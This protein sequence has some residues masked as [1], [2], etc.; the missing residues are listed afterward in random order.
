MR[1][2][3]TKMYI[4]RLEKKKVSFEDKPTMESVDNLVS[5]ERFVFSIH[6]LPFPRIPIIKELYELDIGFCTL[7]EGMTIH[8]FGSWVDPYTNYTFAM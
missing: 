3:L 1:D 8:E 7:L 6:G 2:E 4:P 5:L